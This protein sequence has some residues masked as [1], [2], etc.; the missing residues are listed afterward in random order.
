MSISR[1]RTL[2][3]Q[4]QILNRGDSSGLGGFE[5]AF[6]LPNSGRMPHFSQSFCFYLPDSLARD[7]KL[8]AYFF[9]RPTVSINQTKA[10]FENL[11]FAIG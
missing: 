10:L 11:P 2:C 1:M 9:K 6:E 8:A 3:V 7:T 5:K 4:I